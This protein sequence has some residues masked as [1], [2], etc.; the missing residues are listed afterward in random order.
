MSD[1]GHIGTNLRHLLGMHDLQQGQLAAYVGLS[2]QGMWNILN[3][4]SQP[5]M[6]TAHALATAFGVRID[7]LFTATGDCVRAAADA[8]DRAPVRTATEAE[9]PSAPG[10]AGANG[11]HPAGGASAEGFRRGPP[12]AA[13]LY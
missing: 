3:G 1:R 4:R 9:A 2:P 10:G 11:A 6:S 7:D 5:R 8:F 13:P 12:T